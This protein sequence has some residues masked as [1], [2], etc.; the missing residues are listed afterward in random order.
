[1][2]R[3]MTPRGGGTAE[4][5]D[6]SA[7]TSQVAPADGILARFGEADPATQRRLLKKALLVAANAQ[8][9]VAEQRARIAYLEALSSTDELTGVLNRRGFRHELS[10][11]L[12]RAERY[13][14]TG[15]LLLIDLDDF[16]RTNTRFGHGAGDDVLR[17]LARLLG[18]QVRRS[19]FVARLGG[20]EFA[21]VLTNTP[22]GKGHRRAVML[23]RLINSSR[24][25]WQSHELAL[26][27]SLGVTVFGPGDDQARVLKRADHAMYQRKKRR[28]RRAANRSVAAT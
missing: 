19:D 14:E 17:F 8:R 27:A 13:G 2:S 24:V 7:I 21:V 5:L 16:K 28:A 22:V 11:C 26:Q 1:M 10:R 20:D 25:T 18:R 3:T 15:L 6:I 12:A 23:D 4:T 9:Q